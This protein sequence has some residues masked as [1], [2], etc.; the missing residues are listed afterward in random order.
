VS[1]K[2]RGIGLSLSSLLQ[3]FTMVQFDWEAQRVVVAHASALWKR[4]AQKSQKISIPA[5]FRPSRIISYAIG[6]FCLFLGFLIFAFIKVCMPS[7]LVLG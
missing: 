7:P 2:P 5:R 6:V 4:A 1:N 3:R